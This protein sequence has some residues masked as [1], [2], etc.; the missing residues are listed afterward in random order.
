MSEELKNRIWLIRQKRLESSAEGCQR[1]HWCNL[2]WQAVPHLRASSQKGSTCIPRL[3]G[4]CLRSGTLLR[5]WKK[6]WPDVSRTTYIE[7][8]TEL[9]GVFSIGKPHQTPELET[10]TKSRCTIE[11]IKTQHTQTNNEKTTQIKC[12]CMVWTLMQ[13]RNW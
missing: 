7:Y 10:P 6:L 3:R 13:Q 4:T 2:W 5:A 8:N 1:W 9:M 11:P 12:V